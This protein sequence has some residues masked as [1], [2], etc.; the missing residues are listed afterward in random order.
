MKS[1]H[2]VFI[3][4]GEQSADI[5]G[6][7]LSRHLKSLKP[8]V[9]IVGIGGKILKDAGV[10]IYR[11]NADLAVV[12]FWEVLKHYSKF[13]RLLS[14]VIDYIDKESIDTVI[15]IDYPGF[16]L[17]LA[18]G[19]KNHKAKVL[20]YISPQLWAWGFER[21][22]IIKKY[23]DH[24]FVIFEF[25]KQIYEKAKIPVSYVGHPLLDTFN[26]ELS[27]EKFKKALPEKKGGPLIAFLPGSRSSEIT[28]LLP[29]YL[30]SI[31][32]LRKKNPGLRFVL[33]A[34]SVQRM[35]EIEVIQTEYCRKSKAEKVFVYLGDVNEVIR[36]ADVVVVASGT[37]SLQTALF[38]KPMM[39]V[40]TVNPVSY[41]IIR[42]L[43]KTKYISIV[44]IVAQQE[45]IPELI[46]KE[47]NPQKIVQWVSR[48]LEDK[49][50]A[51]EMVQKLK[52]VREKLGTP[53]ASQ[54]AAEI[55]S[56][57]LS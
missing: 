7:L 28:R 1:Q 30:Q 37:A 21:L 39:V 57:L 52:A 53:G 6:A 47:C 42:S 31:R 44:N 23:V 2:S 45:I 10:E 15:L 8:E 19:L 3:I 16:N 54:R 17:R 9:R 48:Y 55:I 27:T 29:V 25:E 26:P 13:K 5:H 18:E 35:N 22:K 51:E 24:I 41:W 20:Y 56:G 50:Y 4:C 33:S 43:I 11:D 36:E 38:L 40:Y 34:A 46:Q 49:A 32:L 14:D 12:G